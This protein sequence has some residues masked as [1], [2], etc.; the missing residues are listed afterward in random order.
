[1]TVERIVP[2]LTVSDLSLAVREHTTALG[3]RVVMDHGWI[4]TLEGAGGR[5]LSL[6]TRDATAPVN[7]DVSVFVDDIGAA[8]DAA[9]TAG[10][11][12]LHP[13]TDEDWGVTRF[14]YR[15]SSGN[16]V[17]VGAHSG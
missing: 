11:E 2:N 4:V 8:Y 9:T 3:L 13:L 14:C 12:I 6:I 17:N 5:Q 7:P 16:V 1:M 15:D 10:V